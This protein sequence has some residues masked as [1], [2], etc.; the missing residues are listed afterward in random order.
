MATFDDINAFGNVTDTTWGRSSTTE[1]ATS[2]IKMKLIN[3]SLAQAIYTTVITVAGNFNANARDYNYDVAEKAL[4]AYVKNVKKAYKDATGRT[5][6]MKI[7]D[8]QQSVDPIDLNAFSALQT[9]RTCYYRC[10]AM[11]EVSF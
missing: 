5:I 6:Q 10:H 9:V 1:S 8:I 11:V 2:S 7:V 3:D 4:D